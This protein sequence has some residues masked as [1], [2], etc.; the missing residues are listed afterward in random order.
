MTTPPNP[1]VQHFIDAII[2]GPARYTESHHLDPLLALVIVI[3]VLAGELV[4][5]YVVM[6]GIFTFLQNIPSL[7][8]LLLRKCGVGEKEA[9]QTFL[10]LTFPADT[11]KSAFATEQLHILLRGLVKYYGFWDRLAARKKPY[12][13]ELVGENDDGIRFILMIPESERETV[14]HNLL[15]FLPG[16]KIRQ[17]ED[18]AASIPDNL[19]EV[20]ELRLTGDFILPLKSHKA[21]EEHDP[22]AY[23]AGHM[24]KLSPNELV[25][26]QIVTVPVYRHTH[27]RVLRRQINME[28]RI[29]LGKDVFSK[30]KRQRTPL[31]YA[32][33]FLWYPPLWFLAAMGKF[34][35]V[36]GSIIFAVFADDRSSGVMNS[37][38]DK[39][40]LDN[41]YDI[42]MGQNIKEK[43]DQQLF[44]VT[45]RI[46]VSSPDATTHYSRI[47][48]MVEAFRPFRSTYQAI[49]V[50]QS[51]PLLAPKGKRLGQF[52]ARLLSPHHASQQTVLSSSELAD[53][54]HFPNTDLTK[55]EGFVKSRSRELAAPLSIKHSEA[56]LDVV[57]GVN[58]HGGDYQEIG[59]TLGQRQKHTYVIGKTGTGKTTLLKSSI[60]QD[61]VNGKGLAVFDPHGDMFQELLSIVPK[62]RQKDVV[63]FDPSDGDWPIGLN[64]LDPGIEFES[65]DVKHARITSTVLSVFRK[66]ADDSQWGPRMEHILRN[67]TL[68]AL[69]LPNPSLYTLQRLLTDKKYQREAAKTLDDPVLKQFWDKEFKLLGTMQLSTV[70]APLTHRLGHFITSKMSRHILL[71][72]KSTVRIA[73]IMNDGKILLVNLSKGDIGEDQSLFFG[74]ILT[75]FIWMAAYQRTKIPEKQRRDFFVYVDEFQN[76][77][78]P[79]FSDITSEGRKYHVSLIV[80]HQNIAQ[81]EDKDIVKVVASNAST[82]I[83]LKVGPED[84]TFILPYMRP[85]VE[86]GDIV[87]LAPYRFYMK[88][89]GDVSEDAFSGITVPLDIEESSK[90]KQ[91]VTAYSRK[92]YAT[93]KAT[94]EQYLKVLFGQEKENAEDKKPNRPAPKRTNP[95]KQKSPAKPSVK[96]PKSK[97]SGRVH[98]G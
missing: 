24:T 81:I 45:I 94:V 53:L 29:A 27:H 42:E 35:G 41:P 74:T 77:A 52:K 64:I 69:Q 47:N 97:G 30:I 13:L 26:F 92:R 73:D 60:Y 34:I 66:L 15:S 11:T 91:S 39:R 18:Y 46:L 8:S 17:V 65:E 6:Y 20:V 44:E 33:R 72:E 28:A 93:P 80:S 2:N 12:S 7:F 98:E 10:E 87:N 43:L 88:T 21:L 89:T 22:F 48:A 40:R 5:L 78:T 55:T 95:T 83:C 58:E 76:F 96:N 51:V 49:G 84:E 61:M 82:I 79:Q 4:L 50:R 67:T 57:V 38:K 75:S 68:T 62:N 63:V 54:Y 85:E 86:Q 90:V 14:E 9:P 23:L 59:M 31:G 71:Q 32:L 3:G 37:S 56:N 70:T 19:A 36:V 16:L 25:A 1:A